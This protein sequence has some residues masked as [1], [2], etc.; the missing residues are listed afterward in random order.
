LIEDQ[1]KTT[2]YFARRETYL[3]LVRLRQYELDRWN[4]KE[5]TMASPDKK[6]VQ[7]SLGTN[8]SY[9][10]SILHSLLGKL[11]TGIYASRGLTSHQWKVLSILYYWPPMPAVRIINL[12]TLD[13]A[14][15]SR[16]VAGLLNL[17]L[18]HRYLDNDSG[19][20][21][22][23]LTDLGRTTYRSMA[24][25]MAHLQRDVFANLGVSKQKLFF[26]ILDEIEHALRVATGA[27]VVEQAR[28][29]GRNGRKTLPPAKKSGAKPKPRASAKSNLSLNS[30]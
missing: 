26:S 15:I 23:A 27:E 11:T 29:R 8:L 22:I 25:E 16:G 10:I 12:V 7:S 17:K 18:A 3:D 14:A 6:P 19:M 5:N 13:K 2:G 1:I 4:L 9:R 21:F 28:G 30:N 20:I 24:A